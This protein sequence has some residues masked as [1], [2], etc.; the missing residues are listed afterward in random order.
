MAKS[1]YYIDLAKPKSGAP[2]FFVLFFVFCWHLLICENTLI[3]VVK[4]KNKKK[5]K[6]FMSLLRAEPGSTAF[7]VQTTVKTMVVD[8]KKQK[9][10][11]LLYL[12]SKPMQKD[13]NTIGVPTEFATEPTRQI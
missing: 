8:R 5:K 9:A 12:A 6:T 4:L 11:A 13:A 3:Q 10:L 7:T 1:I 2:R